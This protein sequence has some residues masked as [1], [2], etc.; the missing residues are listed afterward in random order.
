M[1]NVED[2]LRGAARKARDVI[3]SKE[4]NSASRRSA[5]RR[6]DEFMAREK[7]ISRKHRQNTEKFDT[8]EDRTSGQFETRSR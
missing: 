6:Q 4:E 5:Q 2:G 7:V 8:P 3:R 1:T